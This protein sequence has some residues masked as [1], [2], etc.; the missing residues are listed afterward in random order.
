MAEID[1]RNNPWMGLV[2]YEEG[3]TLYGR[4]NEV[5]LL[6]HLISDNIAVVVY[7]KSGIGKSSLLKAGV[8]P[9]LRNDNYVPI[10]IRLKHNTSETYVV[11]IEKAIKMADG[12]QVK[13]LLQNKVSDLGLW[14]FIH[15]SEIT[16]V[17]GRPVTPVIVLDQFEEIYTLSDAEHK[18]DVHMFF[19]QLADVLNDTK[20]D[21]VIKEER[22]CAIESKT[23]TS[24]N[25]SSGFTLRPVAKTSLNYKEEAQFR[26]VICLRDDS[27]YLLERNCITIPCL[28]TN[29]FNLNA[30]KEEGAKEVII[31][32]KPG[33]INEDQCQEIIKRYS[34]LNNDGEKVID[35]AILSL[36]LYLYY[37]NNGK[38]HY[39]EIF[40]QYYEKC[41][42]EVKEDTVSYLEDALIT[43]GGFRYQVSADELFGKNDERKKDIEKL[44]MDY[45]ILKAERYN[46][47]KKYEY[48]HDR[49]CL[50]AK[51][52]KDERLLRK[53]NKKMRIRI[54]HQLS[55]LIAIVASIIVGQYY[56]RTQQ[57]S[58]RRVI[59][60]KMEKDSID[61]ILRGLQ[62]NLDAE[63]ESKKEILKQIQDTAK[64]YNETNVFDYIE[65]VNQIN[66][67]GDSTE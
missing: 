12:I 14:D 37:E 60:I 36:F 29:R 42:K 11:Q 18:A 28:K 58:L 34:E 61:N 1:Y 66:K 10:Y 39:D 43:E 49:L 40:T 16:N 52:H 9:V 24:D 41:I 44:H 30:L 31:G 35:P 46:G 25:K 63:R 67:F 17:E 59:K 3:Q 20:P 6:H 53:Q 56:E 21:L 57:H 55:F 33:Y 47:I 45:H 5:S 22:I 32:P 50:A 48:S 26:I 64:K 4:E 19:S 54:A 65:F 51:K 13:D 8:F 62:N 2:G 15:R 27:L 7:G 38:M 23:T